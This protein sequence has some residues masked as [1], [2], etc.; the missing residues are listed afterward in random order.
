M[1]VA[2]VLRP[3]DGAESQFARGRRW[4]L[5]TELRKATRDQGGSVHAIVYPPAA[6]WREA[7]TIQSSVS[8]ASPPGLMC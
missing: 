1:A 3:L 8:A 6:P 7:P 4:L 5:S 2:D